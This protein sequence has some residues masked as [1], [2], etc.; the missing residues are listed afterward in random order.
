MKTNTKKHLYLLYHKETPPN[1]FASLSTLHGISAIFP[2]QIP[3]QS[4]STGLLLQPSSPFNFSCPEQNR[5][6]IVL[7]SKMDKRAHYLLPYWLPTFFWFFAPA[8]YSLPSSPKPFLGLASSSQPTFLPKSG[9]CTWFGGQ[10]LNC[11]WVF[12]KWQK[13]K[14]SKQAGTVP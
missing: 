9:A 7:S 5:P 10:H 2:L 14:N 12:W 4:Q 1:C 8:L 3:T 11:T 6:S 13:K